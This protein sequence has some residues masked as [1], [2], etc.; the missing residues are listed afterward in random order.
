M[1]DRALAIA[2][3]WCE[4]AARVRSASA[5]ALASV[6]FVNDFHSREHSAHWDGAGADADI[7]FSLITRGTGGGIILPSN[8][9]HLQISSTCKPA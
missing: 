1:A 7:G 2:P 4:N 9:V 5:L 3:A 8:F 6:A